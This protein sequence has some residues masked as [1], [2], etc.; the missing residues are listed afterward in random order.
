[1]TAPSGEFVDVRFPKGIK[2]SQEAATHPSFWAFSGTVQT[3]FHEGS[4]KQ[5]AV[6]MPYIAHDKFTH[7]IDSRGDGIVDEGDMIFLPSGDCLEMGVMPNPATGK[8]QLYKEIWSSA[9]PLPGLDGVDDAKLCV[10]AHTV[11]P[12]SCKGI[13]IR[14]GGRLQAVLSQSHEGGKQT[15]EVERRV[16]GNDQ[17]SGPVTAVIADDIPGGSWY[18][19]IRSS[20][21]MPV[22]WLCMQGRYVGQQLEHNGITWEVTEVHA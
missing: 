1:M 6:D 15:F 3:T 22:A 18:C 8:E 17:S 2:D 7:Y 14:L 5:H 20:G 19:D 9:K 10:V 21:N 13:V 12:N 11:S 16:R 4:T